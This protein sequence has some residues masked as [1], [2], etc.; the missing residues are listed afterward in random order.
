MRKFV[1]ILFIVSIVLIAVSIYLFTIYKSTV[2]HIPIVLHP[3]NKSI[4]AWYSVPPNGTP[5]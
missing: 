3:F 2:H 4:I 5:T 1:I